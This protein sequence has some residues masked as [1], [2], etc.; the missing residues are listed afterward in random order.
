MQLVFHYDNDKGSIEEAKA[1]E[2]NTPDQIGNENDL[3]AE[4]NQKKDA[5]TEKAVTP[6]DKETDVESELDPNSKAAKNKKK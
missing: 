3:Y 5:N 4:S 6:S 2:E 1:G